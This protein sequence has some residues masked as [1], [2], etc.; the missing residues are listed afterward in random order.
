MNADSI[1]E[2]L[3]L[4]VIDDLGGQ[5]IY[6]IITTIIPNRVYLCFRYF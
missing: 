1:Y 6:V 4:K 3:G 5:V 2:N